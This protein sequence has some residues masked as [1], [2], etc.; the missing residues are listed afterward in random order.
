MSMTAKPA[1]AVG[2]RQGPLRRHKQLVFFACEGLI[3]LHDERETSQEEGDTY[4]VI[5]PDDFEYRAQALGE[6]GKKAKASDKPWQRQ[7][8]N[9]MKKAAQDMLE[10]VKEARDMGDPSDPAVQAWWARHRRNDRVAFSFERGK[11][12]KSLDQMNRDAPK[13]GRTAQHTLDGDDLDRLA[14]ATK[15]RQKPRKKP[16]KGQLILDL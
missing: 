15:I 1:W 11:P 16:R 4:T 7:E 2:A 6:F 5:T 3:A 12:D 13:T 9:E 8:G 10:T 14:A